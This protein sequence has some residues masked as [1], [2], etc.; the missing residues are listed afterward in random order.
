[1]GFLKKTPKVE[2]KKIDATVTED[3]NVS[4]T[5]STT[6]KPEVELTL[7]EVIATH[8]DSWYK[9]QL[10]DLLVGIHAELRALREEVEKNK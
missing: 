2:E 3:L 4:K 10:I 1:M 7:E 9:A 8:S 6:P 5:G